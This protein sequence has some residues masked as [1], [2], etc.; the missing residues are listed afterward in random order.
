[1]DSEVLPDME[2]EL[3]LQWWM[4]NPMNQEQGTLPL[5]RSFPLLVS[6]PCTS[7]GPCKRASM[8]LGKG[9]QR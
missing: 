3:L 4:V 5:P 8:G 6:L 2:A 7:I 1:M 9:H